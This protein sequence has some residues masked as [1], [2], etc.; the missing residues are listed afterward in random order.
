MGVN[1]GIS[2]THNTWNPWMGCD[3]VAPE[4]AHCYINRMIQKMK[5][6]NTGEARQP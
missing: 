3:K 5:D 6:P 1:S 4:C 2:W